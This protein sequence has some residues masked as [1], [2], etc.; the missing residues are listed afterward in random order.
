V[1]TIEKNII[2]S[3]G[4]SH[5]IVH[6]MLLTF[7]SIYPS[8][9][10]LFNIDYD[11]FGTIVFFSSFL[12]GLG[13]IPAGYFENKIGCR[14]LLL[15]HLFGS[16]MLCFFI[17]FSKTFLSFFLGLCF[18]CLISSIYHPSGLTLISKN[19]KKIENGMAIHGVFGN[20]GLAFGPLIAAFTLSY[21]SWKH[22]YFFF[23][24]INLIIFLFTLFFVRNEK[25]SI[26]Q[27]FSKN[28]LQKNNLNI[29]L[30]FF[31]I[32]GLLG[33]NYYGFTTFVPSY[34]ADNTENLFINISS[35]IKAGIF[36]TIIFAS[37]MIGSIIAP[38]I[39]SLFGKSFSL[40][41]IYISIIPVLI[42]VSISTNYLLVFFCIVW[43]ILFA[44]QLPIANA[45][46]ADITDSVKRGLG[47]GINFFV[48]FGIGAFA[49]Y[50]SGKFAVKIDINFI[51]LFMSIIMIPATISTF[52]IYLF[53]K[54]QRI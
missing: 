52:I 23:G 45:L 26:A 25:S 9:K 49:A 27:N 20:I 48:S 34:I 6:A 10:T 41:I 32:T 46:I 35:D 24:L 53:F 37:G 39:S 18:L 14:K 7:P 8:V 54:N 15:I 12:F 16:S 30:L 36:P 22:A 17:F 50:F 19:V 13:A 5:M 51:F 40:L 11:S 2:I 4:F 42:F 1:T 44:C 31:S 29:L 3:T 28:R 38:K 33:M 21:F 47:Y 43:A